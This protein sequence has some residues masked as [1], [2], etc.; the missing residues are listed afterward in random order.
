MTGRAHPV[1]C[2]EGGGGS[3]VTQ[4]GTLAPVIH[5]FEQSFEEILSTALQRAPGIQDCTIID[6][7]V[8]IIA[9][10]TELTE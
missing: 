5:Q 4:R 7:R 1:L 10:L 6:A 2:Q 8:Y 3:G 9:L